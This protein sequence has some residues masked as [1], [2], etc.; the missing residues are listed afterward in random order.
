[1]LT[2]GIDPGSASG[3]LALFIGRMLQDVKDI[4]LLEFHKESKGS[5]LRDLIGG[6]KEH[7]HH[8]LNAP[9]LADILRTWTVG[10]SAEV[11]CEKVG[12][13]YGQG[14]VSTGRFMTG[15]GIIKG[16][17]AALALPFEEIDPIDWKRELGVTSDKDTSRALATKLFPSWAATFKRAKDEHRAEAALIGWYGVQH[18]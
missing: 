16:V 1:M 13:R 4:P 18:G 6:P 7:V 10:H 8:Q 17:C 14:I 15:A 2:I 3:A 12:V 5:D 11:F 9:A